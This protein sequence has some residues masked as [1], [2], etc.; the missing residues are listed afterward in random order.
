MLTTVH[1]TLNNH[2]Y[3]IRPTC[4]VHVVW[5]HFILELS[6]PFSWVL[7]S[8]LWLCHQLVTDV[9]V[10]LINPNLSCSKNRK[11]KKKKKKVKRENKKW[12]SLST[13]LT[14]YFYWFFSL[15]FSFIF[16]TFLLSKLSFLLMNS[17]RS[18][19][20]ACIIQLASIWNLLLVPS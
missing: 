18:R 15:L 12:S 1:S 5:Y 8:V 6:T 17:F 2:M 3:D 7:W 14:S 16:L 4:V 20:P 11:E 13:I 9:T 10:W 19:I